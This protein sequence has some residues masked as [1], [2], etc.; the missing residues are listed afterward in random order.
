MAIRKEFITFCHICGNH[1]ALTAVVEDGKIVEVKAG[2]GYPANMCNVQKGADHLIGTSNSPDRLTKPLRRVGA[3]G[4]GKWEEITWDQALDTIAEKLIEVKKKYGPE[5]VVMVL[6]EP[7]GMEFIFGQRF[8]VAFGTPNAVTPGNYC[9]VQTIEALS[10]TFGSKYI[11]ARNESNPKLLVLWGTNLA[12]TG[13]TFQGVE[14][15]K[16]NEA[17]VSGNTRLVVIDP[18][19][20]EIWPEKGMRAS[21]ADHWLKPRP[22][23][24]GILAMGLIK[25]IIDEKLYDQKYIDEWTVGFEEVRREVATFTLD[26]VEQLTWIP[27]ETIQ[28]VGRL[29]GTSKPGMVL[30]GNSLEGNIQAFQTQRALAILRGITAS[31]NTPDGGFM[32]IKP[33]RYYPPGSFM[34]SD[35][36]EKLK[37]YPRTRD[38]TIGGHDFSLASKFGYVPTQ[39][40]VD[41]LLTGKPF[42]PKVGLT[43]VNNPL[44]TYADSRATEAAFRK[45][46]LLVVAE[47]FHTATT[48]I[49]DI[50]LPAAIL[51]EH[52]SIAYWPAWGGTVRA[53]PKV[54]DPPGEA[55]SDMKIINELAKRVGLGEYFWENEEMALDYMLK[56]MGLTWQQFR[57][58]VKYEHG[59]N[60]YDPEKVTGYSTPSGKVELYCEKLAK[61]NV[62]P[63]PLFKDLIE[64]LMGNCE[65]TEEYPFVLTN[66]KSEVF[67]LSGYRGV[68][69]LRKKSMPPT[70][71]MS[72]EAAKKLGLQTGDWIY[73][74]TPKG[75]IRQKL[76]IQEGGHPKIVNVEFG[77]GDYG[78]ADANNNL[79]TSY[80]RPWDVATGCVTLRGLAC[81][82]YKAPPAEEE[83]P[84][85]KES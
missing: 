13:G 11:L 17:L 68:K 9:G 23:S 34:M 14:R 31:V 5:R 69:E 56:P 42:M 16:F 2:A 63:L 57:D 80:E 45:F 1:C 7:K 64:A 51:S 46:E 58:D 30:T 18:K 32:A 37:E 49:A 21:H 40:L 29:I 28:E 61:Y 66:Y 41:A 26:D 8:A 43:F 78:Y 24:D 67:M 6:G 36:K 19:D 12:H 39:A 65:I 38:N 71:I 75:R 77:W 15:S 74:E 59:R 44:L 52:E 22:Q 76:S 81:K 79:L 55:W 27:K 4:E 20:I 47:L 48:R 25:V 54:V 70:T 33:G 10:F 60:A 83:E 84:I 50:V 85:W 53:H 35:L 72:P 73:I 62:A 3:K 82:V